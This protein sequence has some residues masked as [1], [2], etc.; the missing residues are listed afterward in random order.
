MVDLDV[1]MF[2]WVS[3]WLAG[4]MEGYVITLYII[5]LKYL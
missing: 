2:E 4:C 3:G 1:C 5:I